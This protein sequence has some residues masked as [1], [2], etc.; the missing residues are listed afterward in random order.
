MTTFVSVS[1][2]DDEVSFRLPIP[3]LDEL[4]ADETEA[5]GAGARTLGGDVGEDYGED[6]QVGI[7]KD[8][9][10]GAGAGKST[11][12][13]AGGPGSGRGSGAAMVQ[14]DSG[15]F[16]EEVG[17]G[18]GATP[19]LWLKWHEGCMNVGSGGNLVLS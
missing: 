3:E 7:R 12:C 17:I 14:K 15:V 16:F 9:G 2:S 18:V 1:E 6:I 4:E 13:N 8:A 10:R 19:V 5:N 11:R